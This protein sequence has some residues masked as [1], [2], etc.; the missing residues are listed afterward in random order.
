M[1]GYA[2]PVNARLL[3]AIASLCELSLVT[4]PAQADK[5]TP[6]LQDDLQ[7][8]KRTKIDG[9]DDMGLDALVGGGGFS[10]KPLDTVEDRLRAELGRNRPRATPRMVLF[11]YPGR[12]D[13]EKLRAM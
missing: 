12:V 3:L 4:A 7:H 11:L 5:T 8:N 10:T 6:L 1:R 13:V 2:A 9:Q